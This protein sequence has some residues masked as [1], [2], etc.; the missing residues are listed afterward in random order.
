LSQRTRCG[1]PIGGPG[2]R[3]EVEG[4]NT[5]NLFRPPALLRRFPVVRYYQENA[6]EYGAPSIIETRLLL[7]HRYLVSSNQLAGTGRGLI[8]FKLFLLGLFVM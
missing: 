6:R 7:Y 8:G 1:F 2:N 3:R 5:G 4:N